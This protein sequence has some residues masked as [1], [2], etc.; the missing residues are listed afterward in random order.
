MQKSLT[1]FVRFFL[2]QIQFCHFVTAKGFS[3]TP[4][5]LQEA[6]QLA[7]QNNLQIKKQ[8][9]SQKLAELEELVQKAQRLPL[10]DFTISS[11]F[12][13]EIQEIDLSQTIGIPER[14]VELG[15]HNRS[16][17]MIGVRQPIFTGFRL[18]SQIDLAK[19]ST[20]SEQ[21]KM[22][23][24]SNEIYHRIYI[25]FY[26]AQSLYNQRNILESSL[27]RLD[28]QLEQVRNLYSAAQ[29]MAFDTLQVYN[30]TLSIKIEL[31]KNQLNTR[32]TSLQM[33]R[34][35]DLPEVRPIREIELVRAGGD[36]I[37]LENLKV[38]AVQNRPELRT[39]RL[40]QQGALIQQKLARSNYYPSIFAN[41]NYH[42]AKPGLDPVANNW[43]D[44]FTVGLNLRWNL[45]RW[46]GD[47]KRVEEFQVQ[48]NRITLEERE[49]LRTIEYEVE[50]SFEN[51][52][53]SL[54]ELELAEELQTQQSERYRI[55]SVQHE[56]GI[57][58]TNDLITAET[59]L[60]QAELQTQQALIQYYIYL[61][62]LKKSIGV[63]VE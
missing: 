38:Q 6:L 7:K 25:L 51:L 62:N 37:S 45:W 33:A 32:L 54:Q 41:A 30:Q 2:I 27:K 34:L 59:D 46:Q 48:Y 17:L 63:I 4:L 58:S 5:D 60:T 49:L 12:F 23:F 21:V 40:S 57:A 43:M 16:E 29:A 53:F 18:R 11:S 44:Y 35:L 28:V 42:Y 50:E 39:V 9:Q 26:K 15:G 24:L 52:K 13:S 19:T 61:A 36:D 14:R 55:V 8:E 31:K 3:Q 20:L 22:D 56:N 47:Q 1:I 10:L